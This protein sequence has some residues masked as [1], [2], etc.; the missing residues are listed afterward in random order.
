MPKSYL[1]Q[2]ILYKLS[3]LSIADLKGFDQYLSKLCER[4]KSERLNV[5]KIMFFAGSWNDMNAQDLE[6]LL[7]DLENMRESAD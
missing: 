1:Y 2:S 7:D 6:G 4:D 3:Y 5:E